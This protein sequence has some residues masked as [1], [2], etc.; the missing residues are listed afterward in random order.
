[1]STGVPF[2]ALAVP[3]RCTRYT[4]S[5][6]PAEQLHPNQRHTK[7]KPNKA[8]KLQRSATSPTTARVRQRQE[9]QK[10]VLLLIGRHS[11]AA[12]HADAPA[13]QTDPL[14]KKID[15]PRKRH[16]NMFQVP[17]RCCKL[18]PTAKNFRGKT[19]R[20]PPSPIIKAR[21]TSLKRWPDAPVRFAL[22][23]PARS[24]K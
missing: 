21:H 10:R 3:T 8:S 20:C 24:T 17:K 13:T 14:T 18:V 23:D 22:S 1:M 5:R 16:R 2:T 15:R 7:K 4:L 12:A 9:H 19:Q 6:L 11:R